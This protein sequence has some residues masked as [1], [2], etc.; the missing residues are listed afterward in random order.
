[1]VFA[2]ERKNALLNLANLVRREMLPAL[3][4]GTWHGWHGFRRGLATRLHKAKVQVD[5]I[6]EILRHS[7]PKV[8]EDSCIVVKSEK[9]TKAMSKID[10]KIGVESRLCSALFVRCWTKRGRKQ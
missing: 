2:G 5:V 6:Q 4:K 1:L 10:S 9:S 3:E 7:D 8:T